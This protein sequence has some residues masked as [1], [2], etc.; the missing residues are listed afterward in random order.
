MHV[1]AFANDNSVPGRT[2]NSDNRIY[3]IDLT[4]KPPTLL[5][6]LEVGKQPSGMEH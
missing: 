6:T 2:Q 4:A 5:T 1:T 3:V